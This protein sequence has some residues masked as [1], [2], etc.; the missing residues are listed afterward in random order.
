MAGST[1][2]SER[3]AATEPA[4]GRLVEVIGARPYRAK[5][6]RR[7]ATASGELAPSSEAQSPS[8]ARPYGRRDGREV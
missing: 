6:K 7:E 3:H 8:E 5:A 4:R 1:R 2:L